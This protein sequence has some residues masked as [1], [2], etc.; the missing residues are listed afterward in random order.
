MSLLELMRIITQLN[1][2]L[3]IIMEHKLNVIEDRSSGYRLI[4][5][6]VDG[7]GN[8]ILKISLETTDPR[9]AVRLEDIKESLSKLDLSRI[10]LSKLF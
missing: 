7:N 5:I 9:I 6:S 10:D 8:E 2:L 4:M 3:E 1:R